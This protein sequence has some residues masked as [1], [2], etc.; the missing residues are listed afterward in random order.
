MTNS[1][2]RP[3]NYCEPTREQIAAQLERE[4]QASALGKIK[5]KGK[6]D[7]QKAGMDYSR[8]QGGSYLLDK[9]LEFTGVALQIAM[10]NTLKGVGLG[11]ALIGPVYRDLTNKVLV[12]LPKLD[13]DGKRLPVLDDDG[14]TLED[15]DGNPVYELV[16]VTDKTVNLWD[17]DEIAFIVLLTMIDV[18]RMPL[19]GSID[20]ISDSGKRFGTR[21]TNYA[22]ETIISDRINDHLAHRYIRECT[23]NTGRDKLI[24]FIL[25]D[26]YTNRAGWAQKKTNTRLSRKNVAQEFIDNDL[27]PF[28]EVLKWKPFSNRMGRAL[29]A[30]LISYTEKGCEQV[31]QYPVFTVINKFNA[32]YYALTEKAEQYVDQLDLARIGKSFTPDVMVCPPR[33]HSEIQAGG[34]LGVAQ[35]L[36]TRSFT[37]GFK[38][39]FEPSA[40]HLR[41]I[42]GQ[43]SVPFKINQEILDV[44]N[45]LEAQPHQDW[46]EQANFIPAPHSDHYL[47]SPKLGKRPEHMTEQEKKD[48]DAARKVCKKEWSAY[49]RKQDESQASLTVETLELANRVAPLERFWLPVQGGFRGR[50]YCANHLLNS[51]GMGYQ[52]SLLLFANEAPVDHLTQ[53]HLEWAIAGFG[54]QDKKSWEQRSQWFIQNKA[55]IMDCIKDMDSITDP[56]SF[57]RTYPE[58]DDEWAFLACALEY[59]RL[60][61]SSDRPSTTGIIIHID[62]TCSGGQLISAFTGSG[63]TAKA[64]N[65]LPGPVPF[66]IYKSV[67]EKMQ[68][69]IKADNYV[70]PLRGRDGEV[71]RDS[72][73][74]IR[75][76]AIKRVRYLFTTDPAKMQ[77]VRK[78]LKGGFLPR[79]YGAGIG[80]TIAGM[81]EKFKFIHLNGKAKKL[82]LDEA[83]GLAPFFEEGLNHAVPALTAYV[84][85]AR[86]VADLALRVKVQNP[87]TKAG[88]PAK[89]DQ[90]TPRLDADGDPVLE[91]RAPMPNGS[92]VVMRYPVTKAKALRIDHLTT[93]SIYDPKALFRDQQLHA[94]TAKVSF[95]DVSKATP[96]NLIHAADAAVFAEMVDGYAGSYSLIHDSIGCSPGAQRNKLI[97]RFQQAY[98]KVTTFDYLNGILDENNIDRQLNPPPAFGT[99]EPKQSR[100]SKY[101]VC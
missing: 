101:M 91:L 69:L 80:K 34:Y 3:A 4:E 95:S 93:H 62:A 55:V 56:K 10:D 71:L 1:T 2:N 74:T 47:K 29:A 8:S 22:L 92:T 54:G 26:A 9:C 78:G 89:R 5:A 50:A 38:G 97:E 48:R 49:K 28:A 24:D 46:R 73:G 37:G 13:K 66:D 59:K 87:M 68:E 70:V 67:K 53:T 43:Q 63:Q 99:F 57:W 51:Q 41:F 72:D 76:M 33:L 39:S 90:Y 15:L 19:L 81:R 64:T 61:L 20:K 75:C 94:A 84:E 45:A 65:C 12:N 16:R 25:S 35:S 60:F 44:M 58:M 88:K 6:L 77:S 11:S 52:R 31:L 82:S 27:T 14:N 40:Q 98:E 7:K 18:C 79:L 86:N 17:S 30:K 21:P 100:G 32:Q 85:W 42:N 83:R 36:I 96:P 23:K